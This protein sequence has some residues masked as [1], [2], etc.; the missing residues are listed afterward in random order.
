M[1]VVLKAGSP[2]AYSNSKVT[3]VGI[4]VRKRDGGMSSPVADKMAA[5]VGRIDARSSCTVGRELLSFTATKADSGAASG[6]AGT[7]NR[8][9]RSL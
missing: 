3:P 2:L 7:H 5:A 1:K 4:C 8:D 6:A 9:S